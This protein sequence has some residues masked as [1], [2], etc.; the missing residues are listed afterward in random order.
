MGE[1]LL[2]SCLLFYLLLPEGGGVEL[3]LVAEAAL[4]PFQHTIFL[5]GEM[6]GLLVVLEILAIA[7]Y[8]RLNSL[9][10]RPATEADRVDHKLSLDQPEL[11]HL[12]LQVLS[13]AQM[14]MKAVVALVVM[15]EALVLLP[16]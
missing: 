9:G 10:H 7:H 4:S 6:L 16:R 12:I 3:R 11:Y 8:Q 5:L 14:M 2:C 1:L 13:A 15:A